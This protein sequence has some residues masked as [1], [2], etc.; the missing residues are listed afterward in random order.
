[1]EC[2]EAAGLV[3]RKK[4]QTAMNKGSGLLTI[5]VFFALN[6]YRRPVPISHEKEQRRH[7]FNIAS[8][9]EHCSP[10]ASNQ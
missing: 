6:K 4:K 9:H 2:N 8:D 3:N 10:D 1:M 5:S 7:A